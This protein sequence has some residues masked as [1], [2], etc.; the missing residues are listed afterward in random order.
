[1]SGDGR[2]GRTG[3]EASTSGVWCPSDGGVALFLS[4]G[5]N[6][7]PG[8]ASREA[9][10]WTLWLDRDELVVMAERF[11]RARDLLARWEE[12]TVTSEL[13]DETSAFLNEAGRR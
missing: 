1:M 3:A 2:A 11:D 8:S 6:F 9:V 10:E 7:P 4:A 13:I 5:D 12:E